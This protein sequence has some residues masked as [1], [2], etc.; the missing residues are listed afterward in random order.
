M[1]AVA[2]MARN[3]AIGHEGKIPWHLPADLRFFKRTTLGHV[4][5]MGR[6]T[7]DSIGRPLPGRDNVVL[8][9]RELD[10]PGVQRIA[11]FAEVVEPADGR[12]LYVI[13]GAEIYRA[14]LP[15]CAEVLLTHVDMEPEADTFF[16][17]FEAD[18]SAGELIENG[19]DYE[20]RRYVRRESDQ[21]AG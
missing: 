1:I 8:S 20:I 15:R 9:R 4:V 12:R 16:P 7:F 2:A 10:V 17:A 6:R 11:S 13:G 14:L 21:S 19:P 18:F 5:L 3:R